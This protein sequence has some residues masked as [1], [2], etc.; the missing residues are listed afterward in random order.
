[1]DGGAVV[2]V[3]DG[4]VLLEAGQGGPLGQVPLHGRSA[5]AGEGGATTHHAGATDVLGHRDAS[6]DGDAGGRPHHE[7]EVAIVAGQVIG[8][9]AGRAVPA[10]VQRRVL[11]RGAVGE[12]DLE[13]D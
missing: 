10:E 11:G 2:G 5:D 13:V 3:L 6:G 7:R 12:V 1:D 8:E 9:H 4:D